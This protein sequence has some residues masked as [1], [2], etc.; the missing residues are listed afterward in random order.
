MIDNLDLD[1]TFEELDTS[2]LHELDKINNEH[3]FYI[4]E[5]YKFTN[6]SLT[7]LNSLALFNLKP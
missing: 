7:I 4:K 5:L 2:W 1:Y 6:I 3:K